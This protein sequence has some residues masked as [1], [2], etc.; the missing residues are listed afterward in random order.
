[1]S[2]INTLRINS[3]IFQAYGKLEHVL[4][5]VDYLCRMEHLEALD[6]EKLG[7]CN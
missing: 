7:A 6:M 4:G 5:N 3:Y 2:T 1:M